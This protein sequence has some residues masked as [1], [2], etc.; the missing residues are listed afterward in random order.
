MFNLEQSIKNQSSQV[1]FDTNV[2]GG[3]TE[4]YYNKFD[5]INYSK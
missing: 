1:N 5:I 2:F 3:Y 4:I